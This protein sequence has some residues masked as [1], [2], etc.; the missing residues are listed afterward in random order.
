MENWMDVQI[1]II[2]HLIKKMLAFIPKGV[3]R[4]WLAP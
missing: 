2:L 1:V 3:Q 4:V